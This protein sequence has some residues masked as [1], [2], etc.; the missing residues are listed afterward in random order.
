MYY[1]IIF[2]VHINLF[3]NPESYNLVWPQHLCLYLVYAS[4][5]PLQVILGFLFSLSLSAKQ[6]LMVNVF[7]FLHC[8]FSLNSPTVCC[9]YSTVVQPSAL[10][11]L[12]HCSI[13]IC[14]KTSLIDSPEINIWQSLSVSLYKNSKCFRSIEIIFL[15]RKTKG[16]TMKTIY[17][18]CI[19]T[20]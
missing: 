19:Q 6:H 1:N 17:L 3:T 20:S 16:R 13:M 8:N 5:H 18:D 11:Q 4:K 10:S 15:I 9:C 7:I 12:S 2:T 14:L